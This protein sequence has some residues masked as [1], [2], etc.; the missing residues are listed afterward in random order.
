V[1]LTNEAEDNRMRTRIRR[2]LQ[3]A[4]S[5]LHHQKEVERRNFEMF[6]QLFNFLFF[7]M[8]LKLQQIY[9][10]VKQSKN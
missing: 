4:K 8:S 6:Y 5:R 10:S 9:Q 2:V 3:R 7:R 1:N